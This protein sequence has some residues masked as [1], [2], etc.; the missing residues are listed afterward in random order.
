MSTRYR[1]VC[2]PLFDIPYIPGPP[3]K[4]DPQRTK[5]AKGYADPTWRDR[6][7]GAGW[8]YPPWECPPR[9]ATFERGEGKS[10]NPP[11][12][13]SAKLHMYVMSCNAFGRIDVCKSSTRRTR[14]LGLNFVQCNPTLICWG[15]SRGEGGWGEDPPH[16]SARYSM[17]GLT[18]GS[19]MHAM[20][21]W[22]T[23]WKAK[24]PC[25]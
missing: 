20:R 13:R 11:R 15:K 12:V 3:G 9:Y 17:P 16:A 7:S 5:A 25:P 18:Q 8:M 22:A 4:Q 14:H 24:L 19:Q 10:A 23:P 1:M 21:P 6:H 2:T